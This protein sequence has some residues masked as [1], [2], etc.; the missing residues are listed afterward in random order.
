[1]WTL[2]MKWDFCIIVIINHFSTH[3]IKRIL[4]PNIRYWSFHCLWKQWKVPS[5]FS[6]KWRSNQWPTRRLFAVSPTSLSRVLASFFSRSCSWSRHVTVKTFFFLVALVNNFVLILSVNLLL[7]IS[8]SK[9]PGHGLG[10]AMSRS[11][12]PWFGFGF[13]WSGSLL[14]ETEY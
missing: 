13:W 11:S 7:L 3:L 5:Q 4:S 6:V 1:M 10:P 2:R 14:C 12:W 8:A 9:Y